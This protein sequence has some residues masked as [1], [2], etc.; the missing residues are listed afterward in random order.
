MRSLEFVEYK[1]LDKLRLIEGDKPV[2]VDNEVLVQIVATSINS[3]DWEW[4]NA[5]PFVNRIMFG[6]F[7]PKRLKTLGFDIA[8]RVE[9]VGNDLKKFKVRGEVY[10]DLSSTRRGGFA[11]YVVAPESAL[12]MEPARLSL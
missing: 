6:L 7:R 8:G 11:E 2:P 10:G 3:W 1:A 4:L 9:V 12:V 5:T